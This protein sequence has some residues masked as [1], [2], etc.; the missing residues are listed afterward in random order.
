MRAIHVWVYT[1]EYREWYRLCMYSF[2]VWRFR[3]AICSRATYVRLCLCRF[4]YDSLHTFIR[5]EWIISFLQFFFNMHVWNECYDVLWWIPIERINVICIFVEFVPNRSNLFKYDLIFGRC[6][7]TFVLS[8]PI[9]ISNPIQFSFHFQHFSSQLTCESPANHSIYPSISFGKLNLYRQTF[10][11][12]MQFRR[13]S[14]T[15]TTFQ[16]ASN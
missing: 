2:V 9:I 13:H 11:N 1:W 8:F 4:H 14:I 16:T 5:Y 15:P 10:M 12:W 7:S 3:M 6:I